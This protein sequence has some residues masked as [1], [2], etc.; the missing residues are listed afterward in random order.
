MN[1]VLHRFLEH[2]LLY[3]SNEVIYLMYAVSKLLITHRI[4]KI[5]AD[6]FVTKIFFPK[7]IKP[8]ITTIGQA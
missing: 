4:Y 2:I 1:L 3:L 5:F 7:K 6:Y 8:L